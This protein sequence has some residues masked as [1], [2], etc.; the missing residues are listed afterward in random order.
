MENLNFTVILTGLIAYIGVALKSIPGLIFRL[1]KLRATSS[2]Y[3]TSLDLFQYNKVI[4]YLKSF[5]KRVFEDNILARDYGES[6][7]YNTIAP[8]NYTIKIKRLLYLSVVISKNE[9]KEQGSITAGDK[10]TIQLTFFGLGRRKEHSQL[11]KELD[12][13]D[14]KDLL[15][16]TLLN[17]VSGSVFKY[18]EKRSINTL[19]INK[20]NLLIN[21]IK[22]WEK[23]EKFYKE[24]GI[25]Y[26]LGILV[27]GE[28]GTGKST[29]CK[30]IASY[31]DYT[32][33]YIDLSSADK[34]PENV[35]NLLS[36][37]TDNSVIVLEDIDCVLG[38][39]ECVD[40]TPESIKLTNALLNFLDGVMSPENCIIIASTNYK[41]RLDP[42]VKRPGR[43]DLQLELGK[44]EYD[45]AKEMCDSFNV[46]IDEL[47]IELPI[48]PSKLQNILI[49]NYKAK[50]IISEEEKILI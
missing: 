50:A 26:K 13:E 37:I 12:R 31:L 47:D 10:Y 44:L 33:V 49:M 41:D 6:Q 16:M 18:I 42:A 38:N 34:H 17:P 43:F 30:A 3:V 29:L 45:I 7:V 9:S 22:N 19:F 1:I 21:T 11:V 25:T 20:K 39:R 15:Y 4:N 32:L 5:D 48:N 46:N 28:P 14:K 27:D 2:I 23:S 8:G 24:H 35:I 36:D 40:A